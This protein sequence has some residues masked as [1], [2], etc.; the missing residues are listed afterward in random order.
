VLVDTSFLMLPGSFRIDI[1]KELARVLESNFE[2]LV[3]SAVLAELRHLITSGSPKNRNAARIALALVRNAR[4]IQGEGPADETIAK[5]AKREG[6]VVATLDSRLRR[7]L[8]RE[9][10]PVVYLRGKSH[11]VV[12]MG[13]RV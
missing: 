1:F 13:W 12:D 8:R 2:V 7:E 10:I 9:G 5:L 3:P 11:L 6:A 4:V